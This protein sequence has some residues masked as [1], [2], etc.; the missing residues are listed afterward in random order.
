[1]TCA[2]SRHGLTPA[3]VAGVTGALPVT[4][5]SVV[6]LRTQPAL[7]GLSG[8]PRL[9]QTHP[10]GVV[11]FAVVLTVTGLLTARS[12]C[13]NWA[14]VLAPVSRVAG[15]AHALSRGGQAEAIVVTLTLMGTVLSE[16][17]LGA[18]LT[19]HCPHPASGTGAL[20]GHVMTDSSILTGTSLLTL[21]PMF[22]R[23]TQLLT[24][25]AGVSRRALALP[26]HVVTA[27]GV[28][29]LALLQ[30]AVAVG[31][32][33]AG[34]LAAPAAVPRRAQARSGDGVTQGAVLTLAPVT[35]VR[36]PALTVTRA[37]AVGAPPARLTL[38]GV[39]GQ[40][41]A[42]HTALCTERSTNLSFLVETRTAL[43]LP[44]VHCLLSCA[45]RSLV[46][47]PVFGA[48]EPLED[49]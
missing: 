42:V 34:G 12:V 10:V 28:L 47:H 23:G 31:A 36:T 27:G 45:I 14:L 13:P 37:G 9:T 22:T 38:A 21:L 32:G 15:A 44:P 46:A 49:V 6:A 11:T 30:T 18:R 16:S 1:M 26:G 2:F 24:E 43:G 41:A 3:S 17:S 35:A 7:T 40:A 5:E 4:L 8:V 48:F 25:S 19:A 20:S 29:A 33:L 39:R